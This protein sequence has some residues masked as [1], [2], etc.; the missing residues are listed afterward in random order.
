MNLSDAGI[1]AFKLT[2]N[3]AIGTS[4]QKKV[5]NQWIMWNCKEMVTG[6]RWWFLLGFTS[7]PGDEQTLDCVNHLLCSGDS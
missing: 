2:M 1:E 5:I 4:L 6:T 3:C 7:L